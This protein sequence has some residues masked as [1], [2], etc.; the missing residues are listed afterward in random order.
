M[1]TVKTSTNLTAVTYAA[2]ESTK[3][4]T[5]ATENAQLSQPAAQEKVAETLKNQGSWY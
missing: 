1:A 4:A 3:T 2:A 5:E